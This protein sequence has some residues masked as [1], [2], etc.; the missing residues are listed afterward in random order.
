MRGLWWTK[1]HWDRLSS[2]NFG[3]PLSILSHQCSTLVFISKLLLSEG[4]RGEA[5]EPSQK[6][7]LFRKSERW[8]PKVV[9]FLFLQSSTDKDR[10]FYFRRIGCRTSSS[11]ENALRDH[12]RIRSRMDISHFLNVA[13]DF[14]RKFK[15]YDKLR[16]TQLVKKFH[17]FITGP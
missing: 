7:M 13:N 2:E 4:Q 12:P 1:R 14:T 15:L 5:W 16:I 10:A 17:V 8:T 9:S 11:A 6:A 3:C